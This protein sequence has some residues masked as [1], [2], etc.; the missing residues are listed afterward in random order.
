[1]L[2]IYIK[3]GIIIIFILEEKIMMSLIL[4]YA[5]NFRIRNT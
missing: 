3:F 1:M 2:I 5:F 4:S